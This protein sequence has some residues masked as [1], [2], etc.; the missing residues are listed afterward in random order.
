M[1]LKEDI[2]PVTY[3]KTRP[4]ELLRK[5][6]ESRRPTIITQNGEA[7]A[8]LLDVESYE[9][10]RDAAMLLQLAAQGEKDLEEGRVLP[11]EQALE[12]VRSRIKAE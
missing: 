6:S 2:K 4:A 10:L 5:V 7:K 9:G 3:M 1:R 11:Q 8:V 12:R